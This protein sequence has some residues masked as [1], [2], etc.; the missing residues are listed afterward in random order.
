MRGGRTAARDARMG[1][2]RTL[3]AVGVFL[4][5]LAVSGCA[6]DSAGA[7]EAAQDFR[8]A[9]IEGDASSACSMLTPLAREEIAAKTS[10]EDHMGSLQLPAEGP[11][12]GTERYGRNAVVQFED[13]TVFLTVSGSG[14]QVTGAGCRAQGEAPY[15]C[16]VGG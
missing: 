16:K 9:V 7:A 13:D 5:V 2:L 3:T 10:C 8:R 15:D 12:L 6:P 14:W 11:A 4:A 1:S